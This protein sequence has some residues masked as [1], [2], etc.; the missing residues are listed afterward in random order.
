[1]GPHLH[2]RNIDSFREVCILI[3]VVGSAVPSGLLIKSF[4]LQLF[5]VDLELME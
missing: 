3:W 4:V 5:Y 2:V 1:M